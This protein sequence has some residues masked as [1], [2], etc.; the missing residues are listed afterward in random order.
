MIAVAL[1]VFRSDVTN[2]PL[3]LGCRA[4]YV[5]RYLA[6]SPGSPQLKVASIHRLLL[7]LLPV[8]T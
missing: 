8:H 4:Y 2:E 7:L 3:V 5:R 1:P 6:M